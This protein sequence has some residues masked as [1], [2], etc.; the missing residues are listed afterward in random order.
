MDADWDARIASFWESV[1]D[2]GPDTMFDHMQA[3]V[4][5]RAE[6]DPDALYEWAS[7][8]DYLGKE[9]EAV[10]LYPVALDR[11]LSEPRRAQ[12]IIQLASSLRNAGEPEAAVELRRNQPS[13][14]TTGDAAQAFLALAL[15]DAGQPDEALRVALTALARTLPLYSGVIA[16]YARELT[17]IDTHRAER[18]WAANRH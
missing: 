4:A 6:D 1:D 18:A 16:N 8:H 10:P 5:E 17:N 3:L 15:R 9:H 2:T 11:G 12:G 7:V 13:D 14:E